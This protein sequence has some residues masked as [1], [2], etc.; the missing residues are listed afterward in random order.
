MSKRIP[1]SGKLGGYAIV[2]DEDYEYLMQWRWRNVKGRAVRFESRKRPG[3]HWKEDKRIYK[4]HLMHRD[5]MNAPK[6]MDVDHINHDGL[7]NRKANLRICTHAQNSFNSSSTRKNQSGYKGVHEDK[8][9]E[10]VWYVSIRFFGTTYN[11]WGY[12]T[13][14]EA[15]LEY[16]NVA[17]QL[18]GEFANPN[19]K[20]NV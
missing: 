4:V 12:K 7:D 19:F 5:I 18:F 1:L 11:F 20:E 2:D 15:A 17:K 3:T 13:A 6:G 14:K 8:R 9:Q 10:N 16:D